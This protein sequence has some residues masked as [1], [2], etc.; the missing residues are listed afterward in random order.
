MYEDGELEK[1][2][3]NQ[4]AVITIH[5]SYFNFLYN[6]DPLKQEDDIHQLLK[7]VVRNKSKPCR[8]TIGTDLKKPTTKVN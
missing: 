5:G 6:F 8:Q 1:K 3:K 4:N 2:M 7:D